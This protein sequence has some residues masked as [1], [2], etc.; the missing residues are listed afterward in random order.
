VITGRQALPGWVATLALL[1]LTGCASSAPVATST[2]T[3]APTET[4]SPEPTPYPTLASTTVEAA[5]APPGAI[6]IEL[7]PQLTFEPSEITAP[8][9]TIVF[10]LQNVSTVGILSHNML[11]GSSPQEPA[12]AAS[13]LVRGRVAAIFTVEHMPPGTYAIWC[14]SHNHWESGMVGTLTVT[15]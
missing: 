10:Y 6:V 14:T 4:P 2:P 9:G 13:Q 5:E 3:A 15:P 8:A 11:I 1:V 12:L 7:T